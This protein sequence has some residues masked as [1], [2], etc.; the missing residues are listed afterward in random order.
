MSMK[1]KHKNCLYQKFSKLLS[2]VSEK[3][4]LED[5]SQMLM[6]RFLSEVE[7]IAEVQHIWSKK[8]LAVRMGISPSY[9]TQL[10]RGNK[11]LNF[12]TIARFQQVLN[13]VFTIKAVD[14]CMGMP[15][16]SHEHT[17]DFFKRYHT[18]LGFWTFHNVKPFSEA[19]SGKD[20]FYN[21]NDSKYSKVV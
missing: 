1:S 15:E 19:D 5:E 14:V 4:K 3:E 11:K 18:P 9:L 17:T 13:V 7:R 2:E 20:D 12:E 16:V 8:E 6:F 10:Y 21:K